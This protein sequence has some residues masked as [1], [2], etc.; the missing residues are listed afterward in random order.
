MVIEVTVDTALYCC[1]GVL[2]GLW[3]CKLQG[4]DFEETSRSFP[5]TTKSQRVMDVSEK[6][7]SC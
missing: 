4:V 3:Y 7:K 1:A 2:A 5:T 6:A